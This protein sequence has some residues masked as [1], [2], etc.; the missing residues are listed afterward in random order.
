MLLEVQFP[1]PEKDKGDRE[2]LRQ[3]FEKNIEG[4]L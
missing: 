4:K 1:G 3:L 2:E